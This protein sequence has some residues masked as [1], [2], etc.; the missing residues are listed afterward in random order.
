M[1]ATWSHRCRPSF[2]RA[3]AWACSAAGRDR[4]S[5]IPRFTG[6]CLSAGPRADRLR[7]ERRRRRTASTS[8]PGASASAFGGNARSTGPAVAA[9]GKDGP[10]VED[11]EQVEAVGGRRRPAARRS[12]RASTSATHRGGRRP[13]PTSTSVPTTFRT[14]WWRNASADTS[15]PTRPRRSTTR[16]ARTVHTGSRSRP[17]AAQNAEKSCFPRSA[18][19]ARAIA[20]ASSARPTC[21]ANP[22]RNGEGTRPWPGGTRSA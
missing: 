3:S 1:G 18:A 17:G 7:C 4:G 5:S 22:R 6:R 14:M 2:R 13:S 16:T 9:A 10:G 20:P 19:A 11:A 8:G 15:T 12:R 21:Q